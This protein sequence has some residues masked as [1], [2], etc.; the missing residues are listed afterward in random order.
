[1][2]ELLKEMLRKGL[3]WHPVEALGNCVDGMSYDEARRAV[4]YV[5][6]EDSPELAYLDTL[7]NIVHSAGGQ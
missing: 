2:E 4:V 6:G 5:W 7:Y 3:Y 1:M